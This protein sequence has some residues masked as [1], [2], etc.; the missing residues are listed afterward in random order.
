MHIHFPL[1]TCAP[2]FY[3][4]FSIVEITNACFEPASQRVRCDPRHGKYITCCLLYPGEMVPKDVSAAIVTIKTKCSIRFVDCFPTVFNQLPTVVPGGDLSNV[5][6]AGCTLSDTTAIADV[7][8]H[9]D[10]KF[11]LMDAEFL[12]SLLRG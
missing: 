2:A 9:L 4:Q 8:V 6:R 12:C 7:W 10:Q 5:Q 3:E 1:A 11:Y